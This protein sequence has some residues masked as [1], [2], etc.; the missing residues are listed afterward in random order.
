[1]R[2][3]QDVP[4]FEVA[5]VKPADPDSRGVSMGFTPGGGVR[6]RP[7]TLLNI[8]MMAYDVQRYQISGAPAWIGSEQFVIEAKGSGTPDPEI[9]DATAP[10]RNAARRKLQALLADRFKLVVRH[11]T[12]EAPVYALVLGKNGHKLRA[13][14]KGFDGVTGTRPGQLKAE[15]VGTDLLSR[16]LSMITGR[17]VQDRTG[18]KGTY[19]FDLEWAPDPGGM[20]GKGGGPIAEAK[21][22]AAGVTLPDPSAVSIFTAVQEQ[23]GLRLEATRGPVESIVIER[24]ERPTAN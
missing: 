5:S 4:T 2:A 9:K 11:E 10:E 3:Q 24:V 12:K 6:I 21:A 16:M 17:P 20:P 1:V 14:D 15:K 23:L 19:A 7:G 8:I 18:L 13:S 22:D